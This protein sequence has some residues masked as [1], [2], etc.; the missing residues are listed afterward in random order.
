MPLGEVSLSFDKACDS[1]YMVW[2]CPQEAGL[3]G[4]L[5][6]IVFRDNCSRSPLV[7]LQ[8][9]SE[10]L[11]RNVIPN[12]ILTLDWSHGSCRMDRLLP[13]LLRWDE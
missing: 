7:I 12:T 13:L 9:C 11:Q 8:E 5:D 10:H 6:F 3:L 4:D 2:L 1:Y